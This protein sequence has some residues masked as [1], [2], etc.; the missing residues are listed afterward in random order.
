MNLYFA[1]SLCALGM[2]VGQLLFKWGAN[3]LNK[4]THVWQLDVMAV[5]MTA[6]GLYGLTTL[7][8]IWILQRADLGRIYPFMAFA[9]VLVPIASHFVFGERLTLMHVAG[10]VLILA[11]IA[12]SSQG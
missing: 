6:V 1:A 2:T 5:L 7:G 8:W 12:I 11:G 10:S 4:A 3:L 9:F